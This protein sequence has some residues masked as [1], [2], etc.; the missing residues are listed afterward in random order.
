MPQ[1]ALLLLGP[2]Q[3]TLGGAPVT[4]FESDKVRALLAYLA[5][6]AGRPHRR[7]ALAALLW[8]ERPDRAAQ[9]N[10]NQA[11][12]NLRRAIGDREALTPH[13]L[14]TRAAIQL[15]P[16][17]DHAIDAAEFGALLD[18]CDAHQH[19]DP[20]GCAACT[21]RLARA[22]ALYRGEFL[23]QLAPRDCQPF[24]EWAL[25][26]RERLHRRAQAA[27]GQLAAYHERRDDRAAALDA[28]R[29]LIAIESWDEGAHR[30]AMRLL[31]RDGQR[32]A[33][34]A[35]YERCRAALDAELGV[36]PDDA[37]AALYEQIRAEATPGDAPQPAAC[38]SL[39]HP[40]TP[41]VGRE[42]ELARLAAYLGDPACRLVT[43]VGLG[44]SGKT[45]LAIQGAAA[46]QHAFAGG[47]AFVPLA[48][49][50]AA[51]LIA[52]A[53]ARS[54]GVQLGGGDEIEQLGAALRGRRMLLV[55]DNLEQ[56]DGA[57]AVVAALLEQAPDLTVLATTR[58]RLS[59]R[60]EWVLAL[61]GLQA[62]E[63]A[64]DEALQRCGATA[65]FLQ[66]ARRAHAGFTPDAAER[67]AIVRL[68][69][70]LG[71][72]PLAIELAAAW[73]RVLSCAEIESELA[74]SLELL[75]S[76]AGD[77]PAR[78]RT[79]RAVLDATWR[80]LGDDERRALRRL[81]VLAG[82]FDRGAAAEV[83]GAGLGQLAALLHTSL[84]ERGRAGRYE[85]HELVR[86]YA[87]EQ[88]RAT[89]E[90][91]DAIRRHADHFFALVEQADAH[92]KG[93]DEAAW[94][95][96]L[97]AEHDNL[98]A[99]LERALA[100]CDV[101]RAARACEV[102]RWFWYIR[103]HFGE[104]LRWIERVLAEIEAR[105]TSIPPARRG[106]LLQ[107]AGILADEQGDY[108]LA[109]ARYAQAL[110]VYR[111]HGDR[112]GIQATTNSLGMLEWAQGRYASAQACFAECLRLCREL[113]HTWGIANS[114]NGLG[115]AVQAQGDA[116][117]ALAYFEEALAA[118]RVVGYEQLITLVLDN[119]GEALLAL[120]ERQRAQDAYLEAL[121]IQRAGG[122]TRGAALSLHGLGR[123]ALAAGD[124]TSAAAH[125]SE[126]LRRS[127]RTANRRELTTYVDNVAALLATQ[128]QHARA[129]SLSAATSAFR[130]RIGAPLTVFERVAFERTVAACRASLGPAAFEQAWAAGAT[131]PIDDLIADILARF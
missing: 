11:L 25:V 97:E 100:C 104:G 42:D 10:L 90:H 51:A 47:V 119:T 2:L 76:A 14:V 112:R 106:V 49:V 99:A 58:E 38:V 65:L 13:L 94:M 69:R 120:G 50:D 91:S 29:R 125:L 34:L 27:L 45:R 114:L 56:I 72:H 61:G 93:P 54:A 117:A 57:C 96:R 118:A 33:A 116:P 32:A 82:G 80:I 30:L 36:A 17:A 8:P 73:V 129:A 102:L 74:A 84:L 63:G 77:M 83:A 103:G 128:G 107:G 115:T 110:A 22:V 43:I 21:E 127:W 20:A 46:Q 62:P 111:A 16:A 85:L 5:V 122:D 75:S 108:M 55:L 52:P 4:A 3:V 15:N 37:T 59:L 23:A 105:G 123:C 40:G 130:Q 113:G 6:E 7:A 101:A 87:A 98:R 9:L 28:A 88:L 78:H 26:V 126:G 24:Q 109:A 44:G 95:D 35:Q 71:G 89:G 64:S 18:A 12:A 39:P 81:S 86:Q 48:A 68:C 19:R 67:A 41:F 124:L 131:T 60:A 53:V 121:T 66:A 31:W 79:V 1:L 92:M 70:R